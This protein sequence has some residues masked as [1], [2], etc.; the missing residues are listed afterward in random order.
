MNIRDIEGYKNKVINQTTVWSAL[1]LLSKNGVKDAEACEIVK[2]IFNE[3]ADIFP[4]AYNCL[5]KKERMIVCKMMDLPYT[6]IVKH[7]SK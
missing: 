5:G 6:L 3:H 4:Y 7:N 2:S 1:K